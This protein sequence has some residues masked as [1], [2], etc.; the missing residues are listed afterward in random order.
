M[1]ESE[2]QNLLAEALNTLKQI[3]ALEDGELNALYNL[4]EVYKKKLKKEMQRS[5]EKV[6]KTAD[7]YATLTERKNAGK[8]DLDAI[9]AR[10]GKGFLEEFT[11]EGKVS[12]VFTVKLENNESVNSDSL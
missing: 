8:L 11:T 2:L 5:N 10:F 3:K 4:Y 9:E 12:E 6:I 7:G 1:P